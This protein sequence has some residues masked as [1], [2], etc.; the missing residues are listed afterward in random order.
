[1]DR[2]LTQSRRDEVGALPT[3]D[4]FAR[5]IAD[6]ATAAEPSQATIFVGNTN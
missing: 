2:G 1:M 6:A 3:V 5:A 4:E